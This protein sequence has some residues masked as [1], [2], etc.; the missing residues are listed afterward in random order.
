MKKEKDEKEGRDHT[1]YVTTE[2]ERF[3]K[4]VLT[5]DREQKALKI[6]QEENAAVN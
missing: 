5:G 2:G 6:R 4:K 1:R 3:T